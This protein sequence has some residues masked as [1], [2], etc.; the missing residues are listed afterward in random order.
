MDRVIDDR[1]AESFR[2][3]AAAMCGSHLPAQ[4]RGTLA[5]FDPARDTLAVLRLLRGLLARSSRTEAKR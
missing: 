5:A 1:P 4:E 2:A 3:T